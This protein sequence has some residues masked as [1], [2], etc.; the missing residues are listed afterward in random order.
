[1]RYFRAYDNFFS[2]RMKTC[3]PPRNANL[4]IYESNSIARDS[5]RTKKVSPTAKF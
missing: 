1:M 5:D 4:Y 2:D 3:H